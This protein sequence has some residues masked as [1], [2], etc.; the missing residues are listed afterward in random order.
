M[1]QPH[2]PYRKV[3]FNPGGGYRFN[4]EAPTAKALFHGFYT[5]PPPAISATPKT[6]TTYGI[7]ELCAATSLKQE[8]ALPQGAI[9]HATC[10]QFIFL[11]TNKYM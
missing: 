6:A 7:L 2:Y 1:T 4:P 9:I 8:G 11:D 3:L 5:V 10:D